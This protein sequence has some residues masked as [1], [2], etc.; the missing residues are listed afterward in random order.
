MKNTT[1]AITMAATLGMLVAFGA[2]QTFAQPGT[3][4]EQIKSQS[5]S[6][7]E[8]DVF[9]NV[10]DAT[11]DYKGAAFKGDDAEGTV[12]CW[13]WYY[14]PVYRVWYWRP[15]YYRP[16]YCYYR[17]WCAPCYCNFTWTTVA[18]FK[19]AEN[20]GAM[21][22]SDPTDNSPLK[23]LGLRKGD[24]VTAIDGKALT[25]LADMKKVTA[26]SD[27]TVHKGSNVKYA[28]NLLKK[29]DAE[30][31]KQFDGM[32][33]VEA[34][35]LLTKSE[36]QQGSYDMYKLYEKFSM[37]VFGVKA[38]ENNGNGVK[39]T[40]VVAGLPGQKSG[41][42]VGDVILEINGEKIDGEKAY[43]D[44]IDR[45]GKNA[46]MKVLCGKTNKTVDADVILN[47]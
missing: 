19:G 4:E 1:L 26:K 36:I 7:N 45:A 6:F 44:A 9:Y 11:Q 28:G 2:G 32:Q 34:G 14:R 17:Y 43:S 25:S 29:T 37:P 12:K 39:V 40:E 42:E 24:I 5:A 41:F 22:D 27:L 18:V 10:D 3:A 33:E 13:R 21:L 46:R 16:Y 8:A 23:A 20:K 30:Y 47:K 31:A 35:T 38:A 15:V